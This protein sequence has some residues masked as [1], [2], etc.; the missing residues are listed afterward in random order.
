[1]SA[2]FEPIIASTPTRAS[3]V[4]GH[5]LWWAGVS[6][7]A[8]RGSSLL[9]TLYLATVLAPRDFG[10][11][12]IVNIVIAFA[13]SVFGSAFTPALIQAPG[14]LE[15]L[16]ATSLWIAIALS[17]LLYSALYSV[18]PVIESFYK[19]PDL[20]FLLRV[21]ALGIVASSVGAIPLGLLQR[22]LEFKKL[23]AVQ[24]TSQIAGSAT[25][26][27]LAVL[28]LGI[29]A[30]IS[31][32][33]VTSGVSAAMG[34]AL[35]RWIPRRRPSVAESLSLLKF[36]AWIIVSGFQTWLFLSGDNA[37]ASR[38]F[39]GSTLGVYV[40]GFNLATMLPG[41]AASVISQ[42]AYPALCHVRRLVAADIVPTFLEV[43]SITV[44]LA[45]PV[46]CLTAVLADAV[47][48]VGFGTSWVGLGETIRWLAISPGLCA[49]WSLN[50]DAYRAVG[51][52]DL[53]PKISVIS[54]AILLPCLGI[55]AQFGA[56]VFIVARC[57]AALPL[58]VLNILVAAK[59]LRMPVSRQLSNLFPALL[60]GVV[61]SAVVVGLLH[62]W[63]PLTPLFRIG[64]IAL[65]AIAGLCAYL[66][67]LRLTSPRVWRSAKVALGAF[68][69]LRTDC[70]SVQPR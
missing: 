58:P 66:F 44:I 70:V 10:Y 52:P 19:V 22:R 33:V 24:L 31:G 61:L 2:A 16:A 8:L 59:V 48:A 1:M 30:L 63:S 45:L 50:S 21:S 64:Q 35:A 36:S 67:T 14:E 54:L 57:F 65:C 37:I 49:I 11:V 5:N 39:D 25:A 60:S 34:F 62:L 46:A 13:Q 69:G 38:Y 20:A 28:H 40:L 12:A 23:F 53:W 26:I 43:Q 17:G 56:H 27:A 6:S 68:L 29:W 55:A 41:V 9:T 47:V 7:V 42:V 32:P 4:F 51:R 18:A 3:L 15:V